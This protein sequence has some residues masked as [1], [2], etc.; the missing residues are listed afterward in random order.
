MDEDSVWMATRTGCALFS[1][2]L[3][4]YVKDRIKTAK[5]IDLKLSKDLENYEAK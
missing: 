2:P 4:A 1:G 3:R 5:K